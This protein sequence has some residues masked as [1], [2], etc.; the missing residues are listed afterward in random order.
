VT[1]GPTRL[2]W[3]RLLV[4]ATLGVLAAV[5]LILPPN[6]RSS[7]GVVALAAPGARGPSASLF[8]HDFPDLHLTGGVGADGQMFYAL[9]REPMHLRDAAQA[10]D[11]PRY[12]AQRILMPVLAWVLHPSGGGRDLVIAL[13]LVNILGLF[14]GALATGALASTFGASPLLAA[15]FPVLPGALMCLNLGTPDALALGLALAAIAFDLRGR[16]RTA[17]IAAVAAVLAKESLLLLVVGYALWRGGRRGA[18]LAIVPTAVAAA[19]WLY[20][21]VALAG[22]P[23]GSQ[24]FDPLRGLVH[25]VPSWLHGGNSL[26]MVSVLGGLLLGAIVIQ[27]AGLR[28]PFGV[29]IAVQMGFLLL[30]SDRVLVHDYNGTRAALPLLVTAILA[31]TVRPSAEVDGVAVSS[32]RE[33]LA[34]VR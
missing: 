4:A 28:S 2:P 30:L 8:R 21:R 20:L 16:P 13:V 31:L 17:I 22:T 29:A 26:S 19:W 32:P 33:A 18:R 24:E 27:R 9:A 10:L 6:L 7:E 25:A 14:V 23:N 3:L 15:L 34:S 5:A 1:H 11:R 12:R